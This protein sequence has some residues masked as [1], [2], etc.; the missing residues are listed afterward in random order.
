MA[1][2]EESVVGDQP[3]TTVHAGGPDGC[4][5]TEVVMTRNVRVA[6]LEGELDISTVDE[7]DRVLAGVALADHMIID[8]GRVSFVDS[9]ALSRFVQAARRHR[10]AGSR[11][12]IAD[13]RGAVRR[14]LAI[15]QLDAVLP[16]A[17]DVD[18]ARSLAASLGES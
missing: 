16:Y 9:G 4:D 10:A 12:I 15:T 14:V 5:V 1:T 6:T 11:V 17:E 13:A 3:M 8:L 18:T 2:H 7:I